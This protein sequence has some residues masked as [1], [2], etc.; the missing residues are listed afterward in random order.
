MK[1][2]FALLCL[3]LLVSLHRLSAQGELTFKWDWM[4]TN[5]EVSHHGV[6]RQ[7]SAM[8]DTGASVCV[9]DSTYAVDSCGVV[10]AESN[11]TIGNTYGK[12]VSAHDFNLDSISICGVS[13]PLV[14]CVVL[15]LEGVF[16]RD[17]PKFLLG[18]DF[19]K[20]DVW[21]FDLNARRMFRTEAPPKGSATR[22]KWKNHEDYR[23]ASLNSI[24]LQGKIAG[25]KTRIFFDT[26]IRGCGLPQS[27]GVAATKMIDGESANIAESLAKVHRAICEGVRV[28]FS[29]YQCALDFAL[30]EKEKYPRVNASFLKGKSFVLDYGRKSLY[31]LE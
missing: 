1:F 22:L 21:G 14:R 11:I 2:R 25:R 9:I 27:F 4:F 16:Q 8:I 31:I 5:I 26:G 24:Y 29:N 3:V 23:D 13:Y 10:C 20:R 7:M 15:N 6:T 28:E 12:R 17:A 30:L 18:G 19:L